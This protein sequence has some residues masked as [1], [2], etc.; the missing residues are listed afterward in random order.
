[1]TDLLERL[2]RIND[3]ERA[4]HNFGKPNNLADNPF[5]EHWETIDRHRQHLW[6][7]IDQFMNAAP[8]RTLNDYINHAIDTQKAPDYLSNA[9]RQEKYQNLEKHIG[10]LNHMKANSKSPQKPLSTVWN[11]LPAFHRRVINESEKFKK[12]YPGTTSR[13]FLQGYNCY[14]A[15]QRQIQANLDMP[16]PNKLAHTLQWTKGLFKYIQKLKP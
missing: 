11:V 3:S 9:T 1:M 2:E 12:E 8:G 15:T 10:W 7:D 16:T 5:K 13:D 4:E 6:Q 14:Y